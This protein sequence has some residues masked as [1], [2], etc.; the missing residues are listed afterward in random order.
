MRKSD[1]EG[2]GARLWLQFPS[3]RNRPGGRAESATK[4]GPGTEETKKRECTRQSK[5]GKRLCRVTEAAEKDQPPR[6]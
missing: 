1:F 4:K 6:G 3:C 2:R 5:E